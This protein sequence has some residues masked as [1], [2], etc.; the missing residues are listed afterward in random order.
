MWRG[1][2]RLTDIQLG[3]ELCIKALSLQ[4]A[5]KSMEHLEVRIR[6]TNLSYDLTFVSA[7]TCMGLETQVFAPDN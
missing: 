1:L 7:I 6:Q 4:I 2:R 5:L 3:F